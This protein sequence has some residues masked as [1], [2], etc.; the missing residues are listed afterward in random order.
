MCMK[1]ARNRGDRTRRDRQPVGAPAEHREPGGGVAK[2]PLGQ[3]NPRRR[4]AEFADHG[5]PRASPAAQVNADAI[6]RAE[7]IP[8]HGMHPRRVLAHRPADP[9][10]IPVSD[11]VIRGRLPHDSTL[12]RPAEPTQYV[13][14]EHIPQHFG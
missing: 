5:S 11:S 1:H 12:I 7:Q 3:V 9:L 10:L 14:V 8:E 6:P 4:P 2:L 13:R